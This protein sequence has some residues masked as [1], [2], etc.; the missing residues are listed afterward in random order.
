MQRM[1][2]YWSGFG[3][4][5][6]SRHCGAETSESWAV[7]GS[8]QFR[9]EVGIGH[10]T[11]QHSKCHNNNHELHRSPSGDDEGQVLVITALCAV[12]LLGFLALAIDVSLLFRAK[13]NL[14]IA[15]DS[16]A[17]AATLDYLY[18]HNPNDQ[19]VVQNNVDN[20]I[21][22]GKAASALD[23]VSDGANG[24]VVHVDQVWDGVYAGTP[25]YF[26]AVIT[27]PNPT[28]FMGIFSQNF[29]TVAVR[30]VA[31]TPYHS[32]G[33]F[34][35]QDSKGTLGKGDSTAYF[36]G[37]FQLNTPDCGMII[38]GTS[39]DTLYFNNKTKA[40]NGLF[41]GSVGVVGNCGGF[42]GDANVPISS[43]I[44]PVTNPFQGITAPTP[45]GCVL[46]TGG[47]D[48]VKGVKYYILQAGAVPGC[49]RG[50]IEIK[51]DLG[52]GTYE[53]FSGGVSGAGNV[54]I[55]GN[56]SAD[57]GTTIVLY[58][59]GFSQATNTTF[60]ITAPG[61]GSYQGIAFLAPATNAST[62]Q[63]EIGNT[64]GKSNLTG[65]ID[66]PGVQFVLHDSGGGAGACDTITA[67]FV[68]GSF[69]DQTG[70]LTVNSYSQVHDSPLKAV[71]LVE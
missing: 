16:A 26:E 1:R 6:N 7:W 55:G 67:D 46:P 52:A 33:C 2:R 38:N 15:A 61:T 62:V 5:R 28:I 29:V 63:L 24:T 20:A 35:T 53:F 9:A 40:P 17:L 59:G 56:V 37:S 25:G 64:G 10:P 12:V 8:G 41:A 13:R 68:V 54:L 47:T 58:D 19:T 71:A 21:A 48:H 69:N 36:Q 23:G 27:Q 4:T 32:N 39:S 49:Y 66:L 22:V 70:C 30:A 31:G 65:I 43:G 11:E 14:Q 44:A 50:P 3:K 45:S 34:F 42:C 60:S 57:Q 51:S 18:N